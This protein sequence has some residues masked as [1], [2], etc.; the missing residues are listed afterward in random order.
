MHHDIAIAPDGST[1]PSPRPN[2]PARLLASALVICFAFAG[3]LLPASA[4]DIIA[5]PA[6]GQS[7]DQQGRDRYE[8]NSWAIQQSGFD[9]TRPAQGSTAPPPAQP[10]S[11]SVGRGAA[12]G[13]AVGAIGGA[14]GGNA[15]KGA[16]IGA[17]TGG[18][19]S[20]I[21]R[22]NQY[23]EQQVQAQQYQQQQ[24]AAESQQR[25]GYNRAFAACLQG[26][27]YTVN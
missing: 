10:P 3:A 18:A 1:G 19:L 26:R 15:G 23:E 16:A 24:S 17:A 14:I 13:A 8:C 20:G 11:E 12:R 27:G 21:R 4:Q 7:A 22:R 6:K 2:R 25:A 9:P 5:Y